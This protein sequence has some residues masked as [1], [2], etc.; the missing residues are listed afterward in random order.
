[1]PPFSARWFAPGRTKRQT[2]RALFYDYNLDSRPNRNRQ[3]GVRPDTKAKKVKLNKVLDS[4]IK[5]LN[6]A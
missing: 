6:V 3:T 5:N 1:M 2:L 4:R